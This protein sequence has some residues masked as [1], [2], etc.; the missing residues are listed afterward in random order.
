MDKNKQNIVT[1]EVENEEE[2]STRKV[3]GIIYAIINKING[4]IYIG[5]TVKESIYARYNIG[6]RFEPIKRLGEKH[7][8]EHLRNAINKYGYEN[9]EI[10]EVLAKGYSLEELNELEQFYIKKYSNVDSSKLYNM[11]SGGDKGYEMTDEFKNKDRDAVN[12]YYANESEEHKK[13][14]K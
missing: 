9:F 13:N 6:K 8:N 5:Q 10:I 7:H 14:E 2:K 1:K 11:T 3:Y 12:N 4:K